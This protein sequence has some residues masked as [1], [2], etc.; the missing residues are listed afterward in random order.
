MSLPEIASAEEWREARIALLEKEKA[1]TTPAE[2]SRTS[3][4]R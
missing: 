3:R 4:A 1:L 2:T